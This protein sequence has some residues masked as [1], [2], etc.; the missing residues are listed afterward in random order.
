MPP[1]PI[2]VAQPFVIKI[3]KNDENFKRIRNPDGPDGALGK[4][5]LHVEITAV[6][7]DVY[8][9]ISIASG[10][11]PTGFVY[12]IEGTDQGFISTTEIICRGDGVTQ[13]TLGTIVYAKI[14]TGMAATFRIRI[15]V[16]GRIGQEYR[17]V[18]WKIRYKHIPSDA[19]YMET[20][21]EIQTKFLKFK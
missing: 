12:L 17:A 16:R 2:P 11:K 6:K 1:P 21:Q 10:K 15:E 14:P 5:Y 3:R 8:I 20:V 9:P 7:E 4:F 13:V 19:R 18:I